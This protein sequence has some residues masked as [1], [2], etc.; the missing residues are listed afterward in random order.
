[1]KMQNWED[2]KDKIRHVNYEQ[3]ANH[4][5]F[6]LDHISP[7]DKKDIFFD[8]GANVGCFSMEFAKAYPNSTIYAFEPVHETFEILKENTKNFDNI[9]IFEF[10]FIDEDQSNV[11]IGIPDW[12]TLENLNF[13]WGI[14]T[15]N[16]DE[17]KGYTDHIELK[18]FSKWCHE[19]NVYPDVIKIDIEGSE[20]KVI[21]DAYENGIIDKIHFMYIEFNRRYPQSQEAKKIL[22]AE[23]VEIGR[24][25][26]NW[27]YKKKSLF[28]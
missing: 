23:M 21:K 19:N 13:D 20:T 7:N 24:D 14:M 10:G 12:M 25:H 22:D 9:K 4:A 3:M 8:L 27:L 5:K 15:V 6:I 1:M 26:Y 16:Y 17:N 18:G 28:K 11:P 2:I